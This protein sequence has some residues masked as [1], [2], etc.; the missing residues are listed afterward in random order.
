MAQKLVQIWIFPNQ[1][2]PQNLTHRYAIIFCQW[3]LTMGVRHTP[4]DDDVFGKRPTQTETDTA[5]NQ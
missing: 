4:Q 5:P 3:F 2:Q 1:I